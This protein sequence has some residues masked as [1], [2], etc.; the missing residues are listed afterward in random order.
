[1]KEKCWKMNKNY[2]F[3]ECEPLTKSHILQ[4]LVLREWA[5]RPVPNGYKV[6]RIGKL[7]RMDLDPCFPLSIYKPLYSTLSY[8]S[9]RKV[10]VPLKRST[11]EEW[12]AQTCRQGFTTKSYITTC[13]KLWKSVATNIHHFRYAS[14]CSSPWIQKSIYFV[15]WLGNLTKWSSTEFCSVVLNRKAL[16]IQYVYFATAGC[17]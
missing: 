4:V 7:H 10:Y 12:L 5:N 16:R 17:K 14:S 6:E 8:E 3:W 11:Q 9:S 1:M 2:V 15:S 13:Q